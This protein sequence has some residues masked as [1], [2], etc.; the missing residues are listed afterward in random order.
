MRKNQ[1]GAKKDREFSRKAH[2]LALNLK[3]FWKEPP[4]GRFLNLKEI[5][6]LG[7]ASLGVSFICNIINMYV[8]VGQLPLLY[9][10]GDY[11]TLHATIAYVSASIVGMA[12]TP[13]YG[14][15]VQR[16]KTKWGRY[17]PYILFMA[18]VVALLATFASWS[19]Q[20][21]S[22]TEATV[23]MYCLAVPTLLVYNIWFN[24]WNLFPG[25]F[26]PNQQERVDI[27]SPIGLVMGFA[28]TL[29]NVLKD[30]CAGAWG[31]VVAARVFGVSSAV[32]GILC[33]CA[34]FKV[35]ERVFVTE[36]EDRDNKIGVMRGLKLI[37]KNKPLLILTIAFCVSCMK[38][39]IDT[40]WHIIARVKYAEN[41]A[42]AAQIFGAVS[43][44]VG[45]AATPNMILLPLMTRKMNN[46]A[47]MIMWQAFNTG[48]YLVLALIGFDNLQPGTN[49]AILIT[50]LRFVA[51]FNA[52]GSLQPLMLSELGDYQQVKTGYRLDGFIQAM[53]YSV[54]M[55]ITQLCSL[56]PAVIQG[57]V[58]FNPNNYIITEGTNGLAANQMPEN[59]LSQEMVQIADRYA[60]I[61]I[62]ISV[63]SGAL[64]LVALCFYTLSKKKHTEAV[65]EL[66]ARSVNTENIESE[67][68]ELNLWENVAGSTAAALPGT[69]E[70]AETVC[71]NERDEENEQKEVSKTLADAAEESADKTEPPMDAEE[72][73]D[74]K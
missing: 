58:G 44:I 31:D 19:P 71:S 27:W 10:M 59:V 50:A 24:T 7:G 8:T 48:A 17:K 3:R 9:N 67:K 63:A 29:M 46:R 72:K 26:T 1:T 51:S 65:E 52:I 57:K 61:A 66:K 47:I 39:T 64:M 54:P 20:T 53:A 30:V 16:T 33:V 18:P 73:G 56:I 42:D 74:G 6:S 35:K 5:L 4:N 11:G 69:E 38:G 14:R 28:P 62:W 34:L 13:I 32:V 55:V 49:S 37:C 2:A 15:A 41:M 70:N 25:V 23:Y 12:L 22:Q 43:M 60:N 40:I 21:L 68:G 45:F 36:E